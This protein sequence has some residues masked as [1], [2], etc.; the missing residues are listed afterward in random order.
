MPAT[1]EVC[2]VQWV[3]HNKIVEIAQKYACPIMMRS[4]WL[5]QGSKATMS[6]KQSQAVRQ[7]LLES[8]RCNIQTQAPMSFNFL[9]TSKAMPPPPH[10]RMLALSGLISALIDMF[11]LLLQHKCGCCMLQYVALHAHT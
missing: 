7:Y 6:H 8:E 3:N 2:H 10:T 9:V 4:C 1:I 11:L 5:L